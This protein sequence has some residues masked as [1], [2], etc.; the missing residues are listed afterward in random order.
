[1]TFPDTRRSVLERVKSA[2]TDVRRTAFGDLTEGYW[3]PSYH[4]LRLH[5]RS[6]P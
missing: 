4:Y 3:R 5:W 2:D 6:L 1:M